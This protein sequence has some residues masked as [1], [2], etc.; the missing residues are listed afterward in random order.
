MKIERLTAK[1]RDFLPLTIALWGV[2]FQLT[3]K[4]LGLMAELG[5]AAHYT[6]G[7]VIECIYWISLRWQGQIRYRDK[8]DGIKLDNRDTFDVMFDKETWKSVV[9]IKVNQYSSLSS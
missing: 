2:L 9:K 5:R 8:V 1:G 4:A 6:I 3:L 7:D